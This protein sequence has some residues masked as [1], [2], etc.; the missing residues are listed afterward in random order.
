MIKICVLLVYE[1][2]NHKVILFKDLL[3]EI[4]KSRKKVNKLKNVINKSK[5][6]LEKIINKF[7]QIMNM[8]DIYYEINNNIITNFEKKGIRN[9]K[10]LSNLNNISESIDKE[11][12]NI[13]YEY[14]FGYNLNKLLYI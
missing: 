8:F 6:N 12:L 14:D 11:I 4:K 13:T 5:I 10:S 9:H 2:R 1:H 7:K 3:I